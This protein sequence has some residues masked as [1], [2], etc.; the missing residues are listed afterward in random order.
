M[1]SLGSVHCLR[2]LCPS[3]SV[4]VHLF[5][6]ECWSNWQYP[7]YVVRVHDHPTHI[8]RP[9]TISFQARTGW[10]RIRN[11]CFYLWNC[12]QFQCLESRYEP[13]WSSSHAGQQRRD[14]TA[15]CGQ[16]SQSRLMLARMQIEWQQDRCYMKL[17]YSESG[18]WKLLNQV[19][20]TVSLFLI[21][22]GNNS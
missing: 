3:M 7:V 6:H 11:V 8:Q 2:A 14:A 22:S 9:P 13:F 12:V 18:T 4:Y 5:D 17:L 19:S 10:S 20:N 15:A 16:V 1:T 21:R